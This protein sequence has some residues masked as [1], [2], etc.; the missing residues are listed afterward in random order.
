MISRDKR[1]QEQNS[2]MFP[3][4]SRGSSADTIPRKI[5]QRKEHIE[6]KTDAMTKLTE[7][8]TKYT[9]IKKCQNKRMQVETHV[10]SSSFTFA[11]FVF[12]LS[13]CL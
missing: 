2:I 5:E 12:S 1:Q 3:I 10:T 6:E 8:K 4:I 9:A 13:Q 11:L 7:R